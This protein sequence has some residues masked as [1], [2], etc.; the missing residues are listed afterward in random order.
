MRTLRI[1]DTVTLPCGRVTQIIGFELI[2]PLY[3]NKP[4]RHDIKAY[5]LD[6]EPR[7][8]REEILRVG[9]TPH[10]DW[11]CDSPVMYYNPDEVALVQ[12]PN[13]TNQTK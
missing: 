1:N 3:S 8:M 11:K 4:T 13:P 12:L 2:P 7:T 9:V 6:D 10:P 5:T